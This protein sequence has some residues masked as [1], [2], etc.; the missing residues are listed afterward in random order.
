MIE[1]EIEI[2]KDVPG[3][4]GLYQVS[5]FGVIKSLPRNGTLGGILVGS[6][7]KQGY[8]HV[9]LYSKNTRKD[10]RINRIVA[11]S[12]IPNPHNLKQVN[13][14]DEDKLNNSADNLEW[15]TAKYNV[16][17]GT[18]PQRKSELRKGF[19][20]TLTSKKKMSESQKRIAKRGELSPYAK[21]VYQYDKNGNFIQEWG[22]LSDIEREL[23]YPHGN[24]GKVTRGDIKSAY[25]FLWRY[26][27]E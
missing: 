23:G 6:V 5:N 15:C 26:D 14:K 27:K 2:W 13:H 20:Y 22:S 1:S 21:K 7:S 9:L 3:Y 4:K 12:F 10:W 8:K 11:L 17:Y 24:I 19:R 16:N 25:G 18:L